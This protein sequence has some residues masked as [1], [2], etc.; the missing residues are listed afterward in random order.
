MKLV[1]FAVVVSVAMALPLAEARQISATAS[2][3]VVTAEGAPASPWVE[4]QACVTGTTTCKTMIVN[5]KTNEIAKMGDQLSSRFERTG[6]G[7]E[8][9]RAQSA[10]DRA[11]Q[12]L[13][14]Q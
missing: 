4:K 9:R 10:R 14:A 12:R 5:P 8:V 2:E 6:K 13:A 3:I 11:S 7:Q 1:A